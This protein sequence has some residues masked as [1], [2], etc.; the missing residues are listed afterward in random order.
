MDKKVLI[1][2]QGLK[3]YFSQKK[4][5]TRRHPKT[6]KAVD[7][8][9]LKIYEGETLGIVGESGCGKSTLGRTILRLIKPTE[10]KILF[11]ENDISSIEGNEMREL[12]KKL[13][14]IFQDPYASLNPRMTVLE[15]IRSPLDAFGIGT[16]S[17]RLKK[18]KEVIKT[19]G[20][21]ESQL[22]RYP[23]E[24]SGGQ[25]QR[26]VIA[27]A[28]ILNPSFIVCDEPVSAL[29]VS[30]RSQVLNFMKQIQK[31]FGLTYMFI[32]H[33]LSVVRYIS[34]RI[35]VMYLGQV[36]ELTDKKEL[37]DNPL[38]PYTEVLLSAIPIP[39]TEVH[40]KKIILTGD[41]PS[42]LS[43]P[44]GCRFHTRCPKAME[45]CKTIEPKLHEVKKGHM[46]CCHLYNQE[47]KL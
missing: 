30:I 45:C 35:A 44:N 18:V 4:T 32:S 8:V 38:H 11:H 37:Y 7:D 28:L 1:E 6:V 25:R 43:P 3:T 5:L 29:D 33:D 27:R 41:V 10:G 46:V 42:P 15:L 47:S 22:Y 21:Q 23:H 34:D 12:R 17:E 9:S 19:V 26:I 39:D 2:T 40:R 31:D 20:I 24:F 14:V 16:M 13:Q 36:V